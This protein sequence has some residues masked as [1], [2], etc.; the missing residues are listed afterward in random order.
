MGI[1]LSFT[2]FFDA[3]LKC[4][5]FGRKI[6]VLGAQKLHD[7]SECI[8]KFA[9]ENNHTR[10]AE[11]PELRTLFAERFNV[12]E[13]IDCDLND[14]ADLTLDISEPI[15][16]DLCGSFDAVLDAGTLEHVFD[17]AS[18]YRN[19]HNL[20]KEGGTIIHIAPM[21]WHNHAFFNFNPSTF[22]MIAKANNYHKLVADYHYNRR[23]FFLGKKTKPQ[24]LLTHDDERTID[25]DK[26]VLSGIF[27]GDYTLNNTLYMVAYRKCSSGDVFLTPYDIAKE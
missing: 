21:T 5:A 18:C 19:I 20:V 24:V 25:I 11:M 10:L 4:N 23:A 26:K 22:D 13:Y 14:C 2:P 3:C 16:S 9:K 17:I 27:K 15:P 1:N 12:L 7:P 6:M 8:I